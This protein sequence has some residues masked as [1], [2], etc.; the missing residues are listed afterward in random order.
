M[1][2]VAAITELT[3][4][5]KTVEMSLFSILKDNVPSKSEYQIHMNISNEKRTLTSLKF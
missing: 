4:I 2:Y 3:R 5:S 1:V